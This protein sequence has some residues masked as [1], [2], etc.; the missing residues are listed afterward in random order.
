MSRAYW[1]KV[2]SSVSVSLSARDEVKNTVDLDPVLD[3]GEMHTILEGALGAS[4]WVKQPDG[5]YTKDLPGGQTSVW[6]ADKKTITTS[7][8]V[9]ETHVIESEVSVTLDTDHSES[10][11]EDRK[12]RAVAQHEKKVR[13][14]AKSREADVLQ[15]AIKT[16][17]EGEAARNKEINE[18]LQ[19][20]YAEALKR[21]AGKLGSIVSINESSQGGDYSM[22]IVI[23]E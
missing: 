21:K 22:T 20:T 13:E 8:G 19:K 15:K 14:D 2:A 1:V 4:G 7:A 10:V 18:V 9:E 23:S 6:S 5:T 11:V 16:L 12:A 3:E 17:A